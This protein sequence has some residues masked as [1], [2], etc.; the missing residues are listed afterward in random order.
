MSK[1]PDNATTREQLSGK[2][3]RFLRSLGHGLEPKVIIG[4]EGL[5]ENL[6][7]SVTETLFANELIKIKL[8]P[9]CPLEKREAA[10]LIAARTKSAMVQLIGKTILLYKR[11]KE[12]KQDQQIHLPAQEKD[13]ATKKELGQ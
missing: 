2:Q 5:S 9:N 7:K 13:T 12:R 6:I 4:R 1:Q 11:N 10:E 3:K 8:G